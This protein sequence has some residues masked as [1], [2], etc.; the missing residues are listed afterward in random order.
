MS[1]TRKFAKISQNVRYFLIF[2]TLKEFLNNAKSMIHSRKNTAV[3]R[4]LKIVNLLRNGST[5]L[6]VASDQGC[7]DYVNAFLKGGAKVDAVDK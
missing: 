1:K 2:S 4:T 6:M 7:L 5:A 3:N